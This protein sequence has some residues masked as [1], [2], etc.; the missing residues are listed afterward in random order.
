MLVAK[1]MGTVMQNVQTSP[2]IQQIL[3]HLEGNWEALQPLS[4]NAL[5]R[6]TAFLT[7]LQTPRYEAAALKKV[8]EYMVSTM[9]LHL[10]NMLTI[11]RENAEQEGISVEDREETLNE[12]LP[13]I[14]NLMEEISNRLS[15]QS[16]DD[17]ATLVN[18]TTRLEILSETDSADEA[19]NWLYELPSLYRAR[20]QQGRLLRDVHE[21]TSPQRWVHRL[22]VKHFGISQARKDPTT[23]PTL[24]DVYVPAPLKPDKTPI[25]TRA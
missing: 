7:G 23:I 12:V 18:I 24:S 25:A 17:L 13:E 10:L 5:K 1:L 20:L 2:R 16:L 9:N 15:I 22:R 6:I 4:P 3:Q 19:Q 11:F 21:V 14:I 8:A